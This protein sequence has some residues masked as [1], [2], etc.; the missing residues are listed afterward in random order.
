MLRSTLLSLFLST[1]SLSQAYAEDVKVSPKNS[2]VEWVGSK[3]IGSK[4][5]GTIAI[6]EGHVKFNKG[7]PMSGKIVV[8]MT[9]IK[10]T[11]LTDPKWNAKLV[12]HLKSDDFFSVEKHKHAELK[13]SKIQKVNNS[14]WRL[15]GT[16]TIKGVSKDINLIADATLKGNK[17]TAVT[18]AFDFD[19]TDFNIRYGSGK[20]FENLGDK[21]ISD[22]VNVKVLLVLSK[23][24]E[25]S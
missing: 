2:K 24:V 10:N 4:H 21:M 13:V 25:L 1:L 8:D 23:P 5:N 12:G 11:D 20:F 17:V 7:M 19:R 3:V 22:K 14:K 9:S 6:K 18:A 15:D 16:L